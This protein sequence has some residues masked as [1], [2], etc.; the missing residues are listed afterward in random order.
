M[1]SLSTEWILIILCLVVVVSYLFSILSRYIRVPSVLL[2]LMAGMITRAVTDARDI[3]IVFPARLTEFLGVIG[4]I[5]I[6]LEAG[7]DLKLGRSKLSLIRSSF[8]SAIV[9]FFLSA[10]GIA[11]VLYYWLHEPLHNCI[12]YA[13]PMAIMSSAIVIPS[14]HQLTEAKK[15]F[16]VYEASFADIIGVLV[17]NYFADHTELTGSSLVQF[18]GN[19]V[20]AVV[21]SFLFSF[22]LFVILAKSR[23]NVKFFLIFALL[24]FLYESGKMMHLP[25]LIIILFFGLLMNNWSLIRSRRIRNAFPEE[26]VKETTQFLHSITAETSFLIRTFFFILFGYSID[27]KLMFSQDVMLI[28]GLIV[29]ILLVTR[30]LY[31]RFF[32]RESVYPEVVFIPRGLVTILLFY[33]IPGIFRL[34]SF[35]EG[36][37]FFVILVTSFIMMLGMLFYK[38]APVEI[39]SNEQL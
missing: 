31:L 22:L 17:F 14:L 39:Q 4:L 15:E 2:L 8:F 28:G 3:N 37:V 19:I 36:I 35:N 32:L 1:G 23:L 5:M 34:S 6:V 18:F 7:L 12:V 26:K 11:A 9:I 16:L 25:S 13:I 27:V 20:V 21:L 10:G 24:I 33:K 38:A 29:L 30:F